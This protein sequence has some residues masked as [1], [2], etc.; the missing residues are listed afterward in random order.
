MSINFEF[1]CIQFHIL[2]QDNTATEDTDNATADRPHPLY[3][4]IVGK[5][6]KLVTHQQPISAPL[7][8][9][10]VITV[11]LLVSKGYGLSREPQSNW[12]VVT[13]LPPGNN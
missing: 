8:Q 3:T 5:R 2:F 9:S 6:A 12:Q 13:P 1:S 10:I 7:G 4:S 11:K